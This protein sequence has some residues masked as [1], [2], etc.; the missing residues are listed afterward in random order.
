MKSRYSA[1]PSLWALACVAAMAQQTPATAP[2]PAP[3]EEKPAPE[4][5]KLQVGFGSWG[6]KG[7][8][9]SFRRYATPPRGFYIQE[10][11]YGIYEASPA[12]F[13]GFVFRGSPLDDY[14]LEANSIWGPQA[15][16]FEGRIKRDEFFVPS[17]FQDDPSKQY[18]VEGSLRQPLGHE[19]DLVVDG[20]H[21]QLDK[22]F[23][24]P[25]FNRH[26]RTNRYNARI[27]GEVGSSRVDFSM[28]EVRFYDRAN[29]QPD[30]HAQTWRAELL[31]PVG[32]LNLEGAF[33][34]TNIEQSGRR[35]SKV[36]TWTLDGNLPIGLDAELQFGMRTDKYD[37]PVVI[38]S[39]VRE[40]LSSWVRFV[41]GW[42]GISGQF[43]YK[44][45][46][47]ERVRTDHQYV[48]VPQW[49]TFDGKLSG[50]FVNGP[51]WSLRGTLER[52]NGA[53]AM[54]TTDPRD[55]YF[56]NRSRIQLKVDHGGEN[57]S[58]YGSVSYRFMKNDPRDVEIRTRQFVLGGTYALKDNI[59]VYAEGMWDSAN[60]AFSEP[61]ATV[62]LDSFF[63]SS[64]VLTLGANWTVDPSTVFT[65]SLTE[66]VTNNDNPIFEKE[67]NVYSRFFTA[68]VTHTDKLGR[69]FGLLLAPGKYSDRV[70]RQLGYTTSVVLVTARWKF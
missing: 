55:L 40:R 34:Q 33:A 10:L 61:N 56:D 37:L 1:I 47:S 69:E 2:E 54:Q 45:V 36:R 9:G 5:P 44:N 58:G 4:Y 39:Y 43:S 63:P 66:L 20:K 26:T 42:N 70:I 49:N 38:N 46:Q 32:S 15:T 31:Q 57:W 7:N 29:M 68:H 8:E 6:L 50:R 13:G 59:D 41:G 67:G 17:A 52:Y 60:T 53:A 62:G 51:R 24:G 16:Y 19:F 64:R 22:K 23:E 25:A 21:E 28:G 3:E 11:S 48:D 65:T 35:D 27:A 30:S 12:L 18:E 14:V